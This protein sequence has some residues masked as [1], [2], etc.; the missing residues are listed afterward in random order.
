MASL[1][2]NGGTPVRT[3]PWPG[4][5]LFD[6]REEQE[7]LEVIRSG[8]W[9]RSTGKKGDEFEAKFA[10]YHDAKHAIACVNGTAALEVALRGVGVE[11]GDEVILPPYTFIA[12]V[13]SVLLINGVPV[14][15]DIEPG[16]CNID[17]VSVESK[18]TDRTKAI[19]AV[20]IGG[21]PADMDRLREVAKRHNVR[22]IE[23]ACQAHGAIWNGTKVGAIGDVGCFSF[24]ASKN[25]NAGEGGA[26]L[27]NDAAIEERCWSLVNCG[28]TKTGQW[29][30]HHLPGWNYRLSELQCAVLLAQMERVEEL[31]QK[32]QENGDYLAQRLRGIEGISPQDADGRVTRNAYHLFIFRYHAEAFGGAPKE[33]FVKALSAEGIPTSTGYKPVYYEPVFKTAPVFFPGIKSDTMVDF[34]RVDCPVCERVCAEESMW[35][36]QSMLLG[37]K[38]DMDDIVAAIE[39]IR[40]NSE[41]LLA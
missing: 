9:G 34:D 41:E 30:E 35:F 32:R 19:I 17:P 15:A 4:W 18:I 36:K 10:A 2:V 12:T 20:H 29:Y 37:T 22:L 14:F 3:S 7:V 27:T 13:T 23:D 39:K 8:A 6:E 28:R 33:K 25:V 24:Q 16:T 11:G 40:A 26:I 21:R 31:A 5:P 38:Q 1:A